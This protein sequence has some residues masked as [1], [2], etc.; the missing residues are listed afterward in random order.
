ML[1]RMRVIH[2]LYTSGVLYVYRFSARG[3]RSPAPVRTCWRSN[4]RLR[5]TRGR[6]QRALTAT[7]LSRSK[8][9][10]LELTQGAHG[11]LHTPFPVC[12]N[13]SPLVQFLRVSVLLS[14]VVM[15]D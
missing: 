1:V 14:L 15:W 12:A 6:H 11:H 5:A 7:Q 3:G 9:F 4:P 10:D 13:V 2:Q 8:L